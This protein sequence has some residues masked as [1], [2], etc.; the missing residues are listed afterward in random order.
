MWLGSAQEDLLHPACWCG[1]T[2]TPYDFL[3]EGGLGLHPTF[4][5]G[6]VV[7]FHL[8]CL[9]GTSTP[10]VLLVCGG[11]TKTPSYLLEGRLG[12]NLT[13]SEGE[14]TQTPSDLLTEK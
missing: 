9:G 6:G 13:H 11:E 10:I 1:G 3:V 14:K 2:R 8:T 5:G 7:G 12:L 4:C